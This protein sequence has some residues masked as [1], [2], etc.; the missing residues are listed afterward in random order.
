V[1]EAAAAC[2]STDGRVT[3]AEGELLRLTAD[4]LGCPLP[5]ILP[6]VV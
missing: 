6:R 4:A 1:L 3:P 5:P 2:V